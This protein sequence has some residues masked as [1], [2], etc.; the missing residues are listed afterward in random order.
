MGVIALMLMVPIAG[1]S[2]VISK[3]KVE[4][5]IPTQA[6]M[7]DFTHTVLAE[8]ATTTTCGYCPIASSQLYS[9]YNSGDYDFYYVTLVADANYKTYGRVREL[10]V[11]SIP[12]VYF[13]GGYKNEL[14]AQP[15]EQ[16]YRTAI[17]QCGERS[18]PDID[19]DVGVEWKGGGTLK[20]TVNVQNNEPEEY[21]GHLRVYIVEEESRWNDADGDPYHFGALDIPIDGSLA[22]P[23]TQPGILADTYTFTKTWFGALHGFGDITQDNI[24]VIASVFDADSDHAVETASAVPTSS[25]SGQS[26]LQIVNQ[27]SPII[28]FFQVLQK[29]QQN[30]L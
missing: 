6:S 17:V 13:D 12:D 15:D 20:I 1:A 9:I 21:N 18:V 16:P 14:G 10:G 11:T 2:H 30:I 5:T 28:L 8:Y 22:V 29:L 26:I 23:Y 4:M 25:S 27:Q 24:M 7:E 3:N 19:I